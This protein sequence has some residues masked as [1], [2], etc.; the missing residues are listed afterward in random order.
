M[1]YINR[2]RARW[3][4]HADTDA[5]HVSGALRACTGTAAC[6][7]QH[8][9]WRASDNMQRA[10]DD[11]QRASDDMRRPRMSAL[12][13]RA[14]PARMR[15]QAGPP[16]NVRCPKWNWCGIRPVPAAALDRGRP[17][18]PVAAGR[19]GR[20][21]LRL[22]SR[23]CGGWKAAAASRVGCLRHRVARCRLARCSHCCGL[24]VAPC[25]S[26]VALRSHVLQVCAP[27][28]E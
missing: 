7:R 6:I 27:R 4:R 10:S 21:A 25:M 12:G 15:L 28:A 24:H 26:R 8:A 20:A 3:T 5:T 16:A 13:R 14:S 22:G 2:R 9:A 23:R 17:S 19:A 1:E 11:M 18:S